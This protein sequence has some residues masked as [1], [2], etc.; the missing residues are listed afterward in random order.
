MQVKEIWT[1]AWQVSG[2]DTGVRTRAY[3]LPF[4][5]HSPDLKETVH[6]LQHLENCHKLDTKPPAHASWKLPCLMALLHHSVTPCPLSCCNKSSASLS[7]S[8]ALQMAIQASQ[9]QIVQATATILQSVLGLFRMG[10]LHPRR[11]GLRGVGG[12]PASGP[13]SCLHGCPV[14]GH[15]QKR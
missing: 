2:L 13:H 3:T 11:R 12:H 8:A 6:V 14:T 4:H 15:Y 5:L 10:N 9:P 1:K 7:V